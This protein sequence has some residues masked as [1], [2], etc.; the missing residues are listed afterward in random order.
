M[1]DDAEGAIPAE[2]LALDAGVI[3]L[4]AGFEQVA[5]DA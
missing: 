5:R 4:I 2:R 3:W 1:A